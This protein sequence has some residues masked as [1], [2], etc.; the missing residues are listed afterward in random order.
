MQEIWETR[1]EYYYRQL[2]KNVLWGLGR[3]LPLSGI[4][5]KIFIGILLKGWIL[6]IYIYRINADFNKVEEK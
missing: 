6:R 4:T 5:C 3:E 1:I 2:P